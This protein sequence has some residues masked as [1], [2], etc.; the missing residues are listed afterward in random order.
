MVSF[1]IKVINRL[2]VARAADME[3]DIFFTLARFDPKL[4]YPQKVHMFSQK[5]IC[6]RTA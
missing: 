6:D 3:K 1:V 2:S 5:G 4:F